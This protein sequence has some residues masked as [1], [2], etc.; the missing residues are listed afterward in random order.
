VFLKKKLPPLLF[1]VVLFLS[2]PSKTFPI[3]YLVFL[4]AR[5]STASESEV[6][7]TIIY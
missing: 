1:P 2:L 3:L 7:K 6:G 5:L 4:S